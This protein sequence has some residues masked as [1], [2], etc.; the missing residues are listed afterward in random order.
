MLDKAI[1]LLET[2]INT[3]SHGQISYLTA[4]Y[5]RRTF[6]VSQCTWVEGAEESI[7]IITSKDA[8]SSSSSSSGFDPGRSSKVSLSSLSLSSGAMAGIVIG[9]VVPLVSSSWL[10]SWFF[11]LV[12]GL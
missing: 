2:L 10:Y 9:A 4:D 8:D 11:D 12:K 7:F 5:E 6:N 1:K 3:D